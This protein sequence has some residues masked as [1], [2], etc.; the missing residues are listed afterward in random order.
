MVI[1]DKEHFYK[2]DGDFLLEV[3]HLSEAFARENY[4]GIFLY[5]GVL[6]EKMKNIKFEE[7]R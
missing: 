6:A 2:V 3:H 1:L 4:G 7:V 5:A